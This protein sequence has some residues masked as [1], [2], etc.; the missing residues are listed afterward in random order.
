MQKQGS[1]ASR[2]QPPRQAT[3]P[4][5][6]DK[7]QLYDEAVKLK[8]H[9]SAYREEN[10][11]LR[12]MAS[13]FETEL[14]Q[15]DKAIQ[16]ML[17]K[18][19]PQRGSRLFGA[20]GET[21]L[22]AALKRQLKDMRDQLRIKDERMRSLARNVKVTKCRE[23]ETEEQTCSEEMARLKAMLQ[24][25]VAQ[26]MG[27]YSEEEVAKMEES[28]YQQNILVS[29]M[30]ED[31][32]RLANSLQKKE[33]D[34]GR[35]RESLSNV[36]NRTEKSKTEYHDN[37]R[38]RRAIKDISRETQKLKEQ[39]NH[40]KS[41]PKDK[42]QAEFQ[43]RINQLLKKQSELTE[44][45]DQREKS[46]RD[47]ESRAAADNSK[48]AAVEAEYRDLHAKLGKC[49]RSLVD[50]I[51]RRGGIGTTEEER[52]EGAAGG[53]KGRGGT[54]WLGPQAG[55]GRTGRAL[56]RPEEGTIPSCNRRI[57]DVWDIQ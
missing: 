44:G 48:H 7:E 31:N 57:E 45:L 47:L 25:I 39:L 6:H 53:R 11:R 24:D 28:V 51:N 13:Q 50:I 9:M 26:K 14:E 2:S 1:L 55:P 38:N 52:E 4:R 36:Q 21:H 3:C 19:N 41:A 8:Q 32:S 22:V 40:L 49:I 34:L 54:I 10:L 33:E 30:R 12:T 16:E 17:A 35:L 23:L 15:K 29:T 43:S 46:L 42:Q 5:V 20:R 37:Q 18:M 27:G 56:R